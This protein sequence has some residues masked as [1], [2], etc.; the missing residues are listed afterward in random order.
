MHMFCRLTKAVLEDDRI[1]DLA[2]LL[3]I[4]NPASVF[5]SA[6]YTESTFACAAFTGLYLLGPQPWLG[7]VCLSIATA[8]RSNGG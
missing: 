4:W 5:Y 7:T 1:A 8:T 2:T 6:A 3:Y